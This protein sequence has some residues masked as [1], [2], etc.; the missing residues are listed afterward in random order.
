MKSRVA[1]FVKL[2]EPIGMMRIECCPL[3]I[4]VAIAAV[5]VLVLGGADNQ[6]HQG[7]VGRFRVHGYSDDGMLVHY[8]LNG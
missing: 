1:V 3:E 2:L 8:L 7:A 6:T 4:G 5:V